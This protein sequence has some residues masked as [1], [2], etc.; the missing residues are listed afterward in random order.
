MKNLNFSA[1]SPYECQKNYRILRKAFDKLSIP[2]V[3]LPVGL[4]PFRILTSIFFQNKD[5]RRATNFSLP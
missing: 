1:S 5:Q 2:I 4:S 3:H